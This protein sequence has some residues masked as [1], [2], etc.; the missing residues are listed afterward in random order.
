MEWFNSTNHT[1]SSV[2]NRDLALW[3]GKAH[4]RK[5]GLPWANQP[6]W[7]WKSK[8]VCFVFPSSDFWIL[9][10]KELARWLAWSFLN[11]LVAPCFPRGCLHLFWA[12]MGAEGGVACFYVV[13]NEQI[14]LCV[15]VLMP[16][17]QSYRGIILSAWKGCLG[18]GQSGQRGRHFIRSYPGGS[19]WAFPVWKREN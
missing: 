7:I 15:T 8:A 18:E 4:R 1:F 9:Y 12:P 19:F 14:N 17:E 3:Q 13:E 11:E 16:G 6:Q 5:F 10:S 2:T